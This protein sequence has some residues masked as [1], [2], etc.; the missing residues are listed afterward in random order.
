MTTRHVSFRLN[1]PQRL[2]MLLCRSYETHLS[3]GRRRAH[4]VFGHGGELYW[5]RGDGSSS[6]GSIS[7]NLKRKAFV[8]KGVF[9]EDCWDEVVDVCRQLGHGAELKK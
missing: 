4:V 6:P 3:L 7:Y 2:L 9:F 5:V 1:D 8:F